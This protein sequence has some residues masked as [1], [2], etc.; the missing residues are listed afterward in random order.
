[1]ALT[2]NQIRVLAHA[3]DS[4]S[5]NYPDRILWF[6]AGGPVAAGVLLLTFKS[7]YLQ[8]RWHDSDMVCRLTDE[9]MTAQELSGLLGSVESR[10]N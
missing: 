3:S 6:R 5:M 4:A 7:G 10:L 8:R 9:A 2:E 1:M